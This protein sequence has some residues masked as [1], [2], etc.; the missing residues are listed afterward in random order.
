[1]HIFS[2][3]NIYE[4]SQLLDIQVTAMSVIVINYPCMLQMDHN[5]W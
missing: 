4:I 2:H 1:M 3:F 5:C